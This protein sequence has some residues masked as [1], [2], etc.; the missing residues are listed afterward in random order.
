MNQFEGNSPHVLPAIVR[1]C[2]IVYCMHHI[3]MKI[4]APAKTIA[5]EAMEVTLPRYPSA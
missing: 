5:N 4:G 1:C 3:H 2:D